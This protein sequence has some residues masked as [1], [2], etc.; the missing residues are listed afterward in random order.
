MMKIAIIGTHGIGKTTLA[1]QM[2]THAITQGKNACLI[3][4][5][6]RD[7]PFGINERSNLDTASWTVSKQIN[8]ELDAKARGYDMVI[9]DRSALDPVMYIYA[10]FGH[11][12]DNHIYALTILAYEWLTTYDSIIFLRPSSLNIQADGVR[13][14]N[15]EFQKVVD[16]EFVTTMDNFKEEYSDK[17]ILTLS[18]S[19]VRNKDLVGLFN[20]LMEQAHD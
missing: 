2:F 4:E 1:C 11:N 13:D 14:T 12:H 5:V 3:H 20:T 19:A 16:A 10:K 6:V 15:V 9:C 17:Q 7:N 18:S 8:L